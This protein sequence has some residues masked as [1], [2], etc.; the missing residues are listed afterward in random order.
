MTICIPSS[1]PSSTS[2]PKGTEKETKLQI[3]K[4]TQELSTQNEQSQHHVK[5]IGD[6]EQELKQE[7]VVIERITTEL[8]ESNHHS[9]LA[10]KQY[11]GLK[12]STERL[13]EENDSFVKFNENLVDRIVQEKEKYI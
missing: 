2:Y 5:T 4:L 12:E 7:D 9:D 13:Q 11:D 8:R 10:Q 1:L 6:L 3:L